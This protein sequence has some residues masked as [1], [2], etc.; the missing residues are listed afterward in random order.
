MSP[1]WAGEPE[2]LVPA[3]YILCRFL[4]L[5]TPQASQ[6][7]GN[8]P[9]MELGGVAFAGHASLSAQS[10]SASLEAEEGDVGNPLLGERNPSLIRE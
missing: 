4:N 8:R 5:L 6:L 3:A 1:P 7:G 10:M 9:S 2:A